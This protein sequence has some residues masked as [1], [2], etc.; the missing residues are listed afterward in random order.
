MKITIT[1]SSGFVGKNII[2][3]LFSRHSIEHIKLDRL[4]NIILSPSF[5]NINCVIHLAGK[6]HDLN[7]SSN[8]KE[9]YTDNTERT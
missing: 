3:Y 4:R 9:Y 1:G 7:S 2:P 5:C 8:P 6:A